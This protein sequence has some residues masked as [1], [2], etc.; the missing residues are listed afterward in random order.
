MR[1]MLPLVLTLALA[2][3]ASAGTGGLDVPPTNGPVT[4]DGGGAV[5][6]APKKK[7]APARKR[8]RKTRRAARGPVL[9]SFAIRA[10]RLYLMGSPATVSFRINGRSSLR[11]VRLYLVPAG[12]RTPASTLKLGPLARGTDH[13]VRVT[14]TENGIL[15]QGDYTV[16]VGA[17]DARGRRLRRAAGI[18]STGT[19]AYL[20]HRFPVAGPFSY[21]GAD[22]RF[23]A[24][25]KGHRHQGQ[26]LSAAEGTPVVAPR[27]GIVKAVQYQASGA[28]HYVVLKASG[29]DRDYVFMHLMT[30]SIPVR[31]GQAVRTGQRIGQVGNTG[32]SFGAH[33]HFEIW[34]GG[35][36][37]TGGQPI[38][39]LPLLK[40]WPR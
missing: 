28:G 40:A 26:D 24:A 33:L 32:R 20:H 3:P 2:A 25:R 36:W 5:F 19:L 9:T 39:P 38:D 29:E 31:P 7:K 6:K 4:G 16:R 15:A 34:T 17:K 35:G 14:G 22:A 1:R 27:G 11:A 8:K 37:Y 18:S 10:R 30:G 21:G 13:R 12:S 23:G